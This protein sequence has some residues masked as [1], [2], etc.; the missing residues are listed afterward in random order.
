MFCLH[1]WLCLK[2]SE[3]GP[4]ELELQMVMAAMWVL[5]I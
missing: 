3:E 2:K 1:V 5:E 4:L